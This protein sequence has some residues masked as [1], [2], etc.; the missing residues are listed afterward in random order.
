MRE[1]GRKNKREVNVRRADTHG[2][3]E[4]QRQDPVHG[5]FLASWM[6][7]SE[8]LTSW[9]PS[10]RRDVWANPTSACHTCS[11]WLLAN[12]MSNVFIGCD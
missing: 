6:G 12:P 7:P 4:E 3:A 10:V 5:M 1:A 8:T 9:P 11:V 2:N